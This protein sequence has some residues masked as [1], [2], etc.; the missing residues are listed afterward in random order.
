MAETETLVG[1]EGFEPSA[2]RSRTVRPEVRLEGRIERAK[3]LITI[4]ISLLPAAF[5]FDYVAHTHTRL[6]SLVRVS[7]D[8]A[9]HPAQQ[10]RTE[11]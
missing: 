3:A 9:C 11:R 4:G 10:R 7:K 8:A 6:H 5:G 1:G 2:S